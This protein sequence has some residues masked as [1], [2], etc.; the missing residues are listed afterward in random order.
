M[1]ETAL[2]SMRSSV[3]SNV[4]KFNLAHQWQVIFV[5]NSTVTPS[6]HLG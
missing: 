1:Q 2:R 5:A 6:F 4:D 3:I